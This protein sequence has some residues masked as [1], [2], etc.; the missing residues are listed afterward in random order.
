MKGRVRGKLERELEKAAGRDQEES[1]KEK[2]EVC[3][4]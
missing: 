4:Y 3:H 2:G 1:R